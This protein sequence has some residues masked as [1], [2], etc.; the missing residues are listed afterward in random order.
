MSKETKDMKKLVNKI[1]DLELRLQV[2]EYDRRDMAYSPT[3]VSTETYSLND[4]PYCQ[5]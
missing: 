1:E 3:F 4:Y 2:L 5:E